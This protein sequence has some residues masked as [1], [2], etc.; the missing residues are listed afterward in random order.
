MFTVNCKRS[1]PEPGVNEKHGT[2]LLVS[3]ESGLIHRSSEAL[4]EK[5]NEIVTRDQIL[6]ISR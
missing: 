2:I 6:G 5:S 4:W 3:I 1:R